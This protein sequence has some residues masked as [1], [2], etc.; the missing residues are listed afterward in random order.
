M[1]LDEECKDCLYNSQLKKVERS[2]TDLQKLQAFKD[3]VRGLCANPPKDYCSPLLMRDINEY[4]KRIFGSGIDYSREKALFNGLLL[5]IEDNLYGEIISSSDPVCEALKFAMAANYIDF[6]RLSDLNEQ[7][8]DY[9]IQSAKRAEPH[10]LALKSF[11]DRLETAKSLCYLHDNCGEIV[12][13]K[14]LIR[15]INKLYPHISVISVVRGKEVINDVT[16]ADA[17]FIGLDKVAKVINNGTGVPGTHLKE[18]SSETRKAIFE[19]DIVISKGLG[20]LETLYDE[21]VS[22]FYVFTCKCEHI[23]QRFNAP[24]WSTVFTEGN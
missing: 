6:A 22:A 2:Q 8:V 23:A 7:A 17:I 21:G 20:N 15:V 19:S 16:E 24:L 4:H 10:P 14:V 5:K 12:L 11:K 9:V 13:D 3:G 1:K 18:I